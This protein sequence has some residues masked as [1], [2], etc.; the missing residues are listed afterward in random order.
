MAPNLMGKSILIAV[1]SVVGSFVV[2]Q[3]GGQSTSNSPATTESQT[4]RAANGSC[5]IRVPADW[6]SY[7][8]KLLSKDAVIFTANPLD[9]NDLFGVYSNPKG[10]DWVDIDQYANAYSMG[11]TV[12]MRNAKRSEPVR[13]EVGGRP[14]VRYVLVG[15]DKAERVGSL[16]FV[17]GKN[18]VYRLAGWTLNAHRA[19]VLP[20]LEQISDTRTESN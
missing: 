15:S 10:T 7:D 16:T 1:L 5:E 12:T 9:Q 6:H 17:D 4:I 18:Y 8:P 14:A 11:M 13:L 2:A 20:R 19:A 3:A